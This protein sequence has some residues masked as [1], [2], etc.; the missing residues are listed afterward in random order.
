MGIYGGDGAAC[1][2]VF[3]FYLRFFSDWVFNVVDGFD[4][5]L[6]GG[7]HKWG[8]L[9]VVKSMAVVC[10]AVER[11]WMFPARGRGGGGFGD[12][13]GGGSGG[14]FNVLWG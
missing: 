1:C 10:S 8:I 6:N 7:W 4:F 14:F 11:C 13:R 3:F 2:C 12:N 5:A 9:L